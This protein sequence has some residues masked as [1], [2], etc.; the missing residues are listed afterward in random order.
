MN[1]I[2]YILNRISNRFYAPLVGAALDILIMSLIVFVPVEDEADYLAYKLMSQ[3]GVIIFAM[4]SAVGIIHDVSNGKLMRSSPIAKKL[5]TRAIP[6]YGITVTLIPSIF[7]AAVYF[8]FIFVTG[9][10]ISDFSDMLLWSGAVD[11]WYISISAVAMNLEHKYGFLLIFYS[12]LPVFLIALPVFKGVMKNGFGLPVHISLLICLA[13]IAAGCAA[14]L[15]LSRILYFKTNPSP[16]A[17]NSS[18]VQ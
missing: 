11:F 10:N 18:Y 5:Y 1:D 13:F 14:A 16:S 8:I 3:L 12:Y 9:K 15:V 17:Q 4:M 7:N 6:L 2:K